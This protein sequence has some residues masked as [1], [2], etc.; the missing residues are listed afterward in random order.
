M[1]KDNNNDSPS[2]MI[3]STS[4]NKLDDTSSS[5]PTSPI[6]VLKDK[7]YPFLH[8][9]TP[10]NNNY[11]YKYYFVDNN[12]RYLIYT[13]CILPTVVFSSCLLTIYLFSPSTFHYNSIS[14]LLN[15]SL[16][17]TLLECIKGLFLIL[18]S[19]ALL[20]LFLL[21]SM[22][23]NLKNPEKRFASKQNKTMSAHGNS[24]N[25]KQYKLGSSEYYY[26]ELE[27]VR[28]DITEAST[29]I[30]EVASELFNRNA[31]GNR[32]QKDT[33]ADFHSF[34]RQLDI[35]AFGENEH[36]C[37]VFSEPVVSFVEEQLQKN[38]FC[39]LVIVLVVVLSLF[40]TSSILLSALLFQA[41]DWF[42]DGFQVVNFGGATRASSLMFALNMTMILVSVVLAKVIGSRMFQQSH[43][44]KHHEH[45]CFWWWLG[46]STHH[47]YTNET[48]PVEHY[49]NTTNRLILS[50]PDDEEDS[51]EDIE[52]PGMYYDQ[53]GV[54]VSDKCIV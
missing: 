12:T 37:N 35:D 51:D 42:I 9:P 48:A 1:M 29:F 41:G 28:E 6:T 39:S 17:I 11:Y 46:F 53:N 24:N 54:L 8:Y 23:L 26:E 36:C 13:S 14:D 31:G 2:L 4:S 25:K 19:I 38:L 40:I 7:H 47:H 18:V 50:K 45:S 16:V 32:S 49:E 3:K 21:L 44:Y 30:S 27:S 52:L 15:A 33:D 34:L 43:K 5:S 22:Q 20:V 10:P